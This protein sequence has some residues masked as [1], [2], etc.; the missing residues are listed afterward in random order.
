MLHRTVTSPLLWR[1]TLSLSPKAL[2]YPYIN[3][4]E[5][6]VQDSCR[7]C[8]LPLLA[9]NEEMTN[10]QGKLSLGKKTAL[11]LGV[12]IIA[13][14]SKVGSCISLLEYYL[15]IHFLFTLKLFSVLFNTRESFPKQKEKL[16]EGSQ[17]IL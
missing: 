2:H 6:I 12:F 1:L 5:Q 17:I 13:T 14:I 10:I 7:Q 16:I 11:S 15:V 3:I 9:V 8:C 4:F